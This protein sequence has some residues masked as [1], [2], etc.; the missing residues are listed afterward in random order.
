MRVLLATAALVVLLMGQ[1]AAAQSSSQSSPPAT[2]AQAYFEF[3]QARRLESDGDVKGALAALDRAEQLDPKSAEVLAERAALYARQNQGPD[4]QKAAE[5]ALRLD[6]DNVEAHRILALVYAA[7]S[8]GAGQPPAGITADAARVKAIEQFKAIRATPAMAT[9]LSL[10]IAYGRLLLRAGEIEDAIAV[11][12]SV[13]SQAPYLADPYVLLAE[14]RTSKGQML[15]AAEA[16]AQAAEINPRYYVS[17]ADMYEKLGRWAA[18]AG[19]YGQAIQVV[20]QPTR[21]LQLRHVTALLNVPGGVGASRAKE[22]L[23]DLLKASPDDTRLLYLMS[24]AA[25]QLQD[26][27][28]AEDA[29]RRILAIDPTSLAG[30]NAL[31]RTLMDQYQYRTVVEVVSPLTKDVAVRTKGREG[32]GASAIA[33]LGLAHQQLG[34]F[35]AAIDAFSTAKGLV[36]EE[37][38]Y[39]LYLAQALLAGRKNDRALAVTGEAIKKHPEEMRLISLRAQALSRLGRGNEAISFLEGAIPL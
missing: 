26:A 35:D 16:L 17:L 33:Q 9:D 10:Q 8:E 36:P 18:A 25:R 1:P 28:G 7:W 14:A 20:R 21:D 34:E 11:L 13:A 31:A 27:K 22:T 15:E 39:D 12:E 5:R 6:Q 24:M 38:A 2:S 3:M 30:L 37:V 32:D 29:A 4:A 19:A 23:A